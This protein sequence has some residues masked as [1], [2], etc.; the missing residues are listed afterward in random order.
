MTFRFLHASDLHLDTPFVGLGTT[1]PE[2][3]AAL[4]DASLQALDQLIRLAIARDVAFV[5]IAGDVYDGPERGVRAQLELHRG[6]SDLA[7]RGI[8]TFVVAGN[9]DPVDQGWTAIRRWP[10]LVTLFP[11]DEPRSVVVERDG[12]H[13]ATVHGISYGT[14]AVTENLAARLTPGDHPGPH[15]AVLHAN[16]GGNP[17]HN[18]YS[19]CTV[20]ELAA[21][22]MDYWALGHVHTRQILSEVPWVVYPG[23]LQARSARAAERGAKG[24]YVVTVDDAGAVLE[25]EFVALD[26]VRFDHVECSIEGVVDMATLRDRLVD[27]GHRR[28]AE[29][30]GRSVLLRVEL[31]GRG[32]VHGDVHRPGVVP[33]LVDS[34][35]DEVV[36]D[37]PFLWWDRIEVRTRPLQSL[38]EL[39]GRNDFVADLVEEAAGL[40]EDDSLRTTRT[41]GWD[42]ELPS[43]LAHLLGDAMPRATDPDCWEAARELAVDLVAGDD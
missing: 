7:E 1:A 20:A 27:L 12:R 14:S 16:V 24:A 22:G 28:L 32:A 41:T 4:R 34:L 19:P 10:D 39:R 9:H 33:E 3:A 40:L 43:D 11:A 18:P 35:R 15:V 38:D 17:D 2:V 13:L 21:I 23:N 26:R 36:L 25:P 31:V 5:V 6:L 29:A 37:H 42:D 30:D 8:R